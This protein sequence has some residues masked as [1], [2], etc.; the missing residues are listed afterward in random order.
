MRNAGIFKWRFSTK[1]KWI[2][3]YPATVNS[4]NLSHGS[5]KV[6]SN[7]GRPDSYR[8]ERALKSGYGKK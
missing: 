2:V 8:A 4:S 5:V 6:S 3:N 7:R 1:E